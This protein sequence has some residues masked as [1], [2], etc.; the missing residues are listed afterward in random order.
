MP[1][2]LRLEN[3]EILGVH[4]LRNGVKYCKLLQLPELLCIHLK[5]F[6]HEYQ[7]SYSSKIS[8]PVSFPIEVSVLVE[9]QFA[10]I[11][12]VIWCYAANPTVFRAIC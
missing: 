12:N 2:N 6:R 3:L 5:R 9:D 10:E 8:G 1:L 4:R 7:M 11:I